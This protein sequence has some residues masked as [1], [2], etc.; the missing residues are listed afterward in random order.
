MPRR[1]TPKTTQQD[2]GEVTIK[3]P[4]I[5]LHHTY[6][7]LP[8]L[9]MVKESKKKSTGGRPHRHDFAEQFLKEVLK[10][11]VTAVRTSK[12]ASASVTASRKQK[13]YMCDLGV[14]MEVAFGRFRDADAI[15][16]FINDIKS[17]NEKTYRDVGAR[18]ANSKW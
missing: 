5:V 14:P 15:K 16:T 10:N 11:T 7:Q 6:T 4:S 8:N 9:T 1:H 2:C 17:L 3:C 18:P 13:H 12:G